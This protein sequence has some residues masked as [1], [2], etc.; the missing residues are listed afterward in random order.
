MK[1]LKVNSSDILVSLVLRFSL[2][3]LILGSFILLK[4]F[5]EQVTHRQISPLL[6]DGVNVVVLLFIIFVLSHLAAKCFML[7]RESAKR[8]D[9]DENIEI[10][11]KYF[12]KKENLS[13]YAGTFSGVSILACVFLFKDIPLEALLISTTIIFLILLNGFVV[14]YRIQNGHYGSS[15]H[16]A[17]EILDFIM[18]NPDDVSGNSKYK[19]F[20]Q[21]EKEKPKILVSLIS[22]FV[23]KAY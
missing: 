2:A 19:V 13:L 15:S 1:I 3:A 21:A 5:F 22:E 10:V 4:S 7:Y 11:Y 17:R 16:E 18:R 14:N 8:K 23:K 12:R 20:P 9:E 6:Q